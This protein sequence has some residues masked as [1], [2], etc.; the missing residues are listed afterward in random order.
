[1][2]LS[3]LVI[4]PGQAGALEILFSS[5]GLVASNTIREPAGLSMGG[6]GRRNRSMTPALGRKTTVFQG[7]TYSLG[8]GLGLETRM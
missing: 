6:L 7:Q 3:R 1:M 5:N 2:L 8:S 4:N